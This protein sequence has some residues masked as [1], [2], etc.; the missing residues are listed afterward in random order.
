MEN[1]KKPKPVMNTQLANLI[2]LA[3]DQEAKVG[4][5]APFVK[6]LRQQIAGMERY[7]SRREKGQE[8]SSEQQ[9]QY[10][11]GTRKEPQPLVDDDDPNRPET[12]EDGLRAG[13]LRRLKA[14]RLSKE[15]RDQSQPS[16]K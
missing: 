7:L 8:D 10:Y 2:E 15:L 11:M 16:S 13:A 14:V 3:E 1:P 5:D 4:P 6:Q 12:E 9:T